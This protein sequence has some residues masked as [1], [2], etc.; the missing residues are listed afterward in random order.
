M[1]LG[2]L[3]VRVAVSFWGWPGFIVLGL[4]TAEVLER[5][6]RRR[7]T[8]RGRWKL[9]LALSVLI[10]GV[11]LNQPVDSPS[12]HGSTPQEQLQSH[13]DRQTSDR[14]LTSHADALR[15]ELTKEK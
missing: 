14:V 5:A 8:V 9:A 10:I 3:F 2:S 4:A 6:L 11:L 7:Y 13:I 12:V 1:D 15:R